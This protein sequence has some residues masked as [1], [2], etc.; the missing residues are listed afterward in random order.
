MKI[1]KKGKKGNKLIITGYR[2][3][4]TFDCVNQFIMLNKI[5]SV[6]AFLTVAQSFAAEIVVAEDCIGSFAELRMLEIARGNNNTIPVTYVICPN[7]VFD[8]A[9]EGVEWD[10]NGNT[11][12]LCGNDGVSTNN[13]VV[14]GGEFQ[15]SAT[16]FPYGFSNKDNILLSGFT[17]QKAEINSGYIA[18]PGNFIIRDC[19]FKVRKQSNVS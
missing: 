6:L 14:T 1:S 11:D 12:Y 5:T 15:F 10:L 7:T 3:I 8:L 13:C 16:Y 17:F 18:Y 19:I 2:L 9:D 4:K